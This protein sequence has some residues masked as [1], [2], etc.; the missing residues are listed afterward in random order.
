MAYAASATTTAAAM[1]GSV[2]TMRRET[3]GERTVT[4]ARP[5]ISET[6]SSTAPYCHQLKFERKTSGYST[7]ARI[8]PRRYQA[9]STAATTSGTQNVHRSRYPATR[10]TAA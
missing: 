5:R 7:Y 9:Q 1:V 4:A 3:D 8:G 10:P 6:P 2:D